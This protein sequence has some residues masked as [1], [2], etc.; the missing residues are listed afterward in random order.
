MAYSFSANTKIW[1]SRRFL[2]EI[3][4]VAFEEFN[5]LVVV[6]LEDAAAMEATARS[7]GCCWI[8]L[9]AADARLPVSTE[10]SLCMRKNGKNFK[11]ECKTCLKNSCRK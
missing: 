6:V 11:Y 5:Y 3:R 4:T 10:V 2:A 1:D 8:L 9:E 7:R